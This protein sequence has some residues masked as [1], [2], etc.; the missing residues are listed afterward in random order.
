MKWA[1][2]FG[3]AQREEDLKGTIDE[4]KPYR[5]LV[6]G[7]RSSMLLKLILLIPS[8]GSIALCTYLLAGITIYLR[9]LYK[10]APATEPIRSRHNRVASTSPAAPIE[11][12]AIPAT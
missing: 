1:K 10:N 11:I 4:S 12:E 7:R 3:L 8:V 2:I 5:D 9:A 6:K